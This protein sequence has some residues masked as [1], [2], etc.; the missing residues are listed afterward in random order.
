[1]ILLSDVVWK[2]FVHNGETYEHLEVS[3]TGKI[4]NAITGKIYKTQVDR[5]GY[6][7]LRVSV[8]HSVMKTFKVHRIV[9]QAF[10]P[11]SENKEDVNHKDGNKLNNNVENLEWTTTSENMTHSFA[12]GL[13]NRNTYSGVNN[14][15]AKLTVDEVIFIREHYIPFDSDYGTYGLA[16]KF[17]V[18][19][20]TI[21]R[22]INNESYINI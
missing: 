1:V 13:H 2:K 9:A 4:R 8:G 11:N 12:T 20:S 7:R 15:V 5:Y 17:G 19:K 10:I 21:F 6:E 22:I 16:K 14:S 18:S 3:N